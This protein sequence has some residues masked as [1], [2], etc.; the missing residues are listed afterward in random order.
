MPGVVKGWDNFMRVFGSDD[1]NCKQTL[2][3]RKT[4]FPPYA[5]DELV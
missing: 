5:T 1:I 3:G 4:N 2:E